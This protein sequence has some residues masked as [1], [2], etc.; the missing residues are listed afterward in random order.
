ML[1]VFWDDYWQVRHTQRYR[2][3][4]KPCHVSYS[5]LLVGGFE[6]TQAREAN[7]C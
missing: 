5:F 2:I 1:L 7:C 6:F 4:S 3:S